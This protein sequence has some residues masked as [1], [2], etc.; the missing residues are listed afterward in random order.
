MK[1]QIIIEFTWLQWSWKSTI[2][3]ELIKNNYLKDKVFYV[4]DNYHKNNYLNKTTCKKIFIRFF[5]LFKNPI[6]NL[7]YLMYFYKSHC[8]IMLFNSLSYWKFIINS[9][10][11]KSFILTDEIIL[12]F[13]WTSWNKPSYNL[14]K[15]IN[16][17]YPIYFNT[18]HKVHIERTKKRQK[19]WYYD[20]LSD[21]EKR[22]SLEK[23]GYLSKY[24]VEKYCEL[25]NKP[26]LEV[27]GDASIE[28]KTKQV[29]KHIEYIMEITWNKKELEN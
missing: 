12:H 21:D 11:D 25:T 9:L 22:K 27:D 5:W 26:Y 6:L 19:P 14:L 24:I 23:N 15:S 13:F 7:R 10:K 29:M 18:S 3:N 20:K 16:N 2:L 28:E 17:I 8:W 1:K 4:W